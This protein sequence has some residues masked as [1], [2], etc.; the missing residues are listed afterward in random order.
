M[1]KHRSQRRKSHSK[2]K[3]ARRGQH[4][5]NLAGNPPS[6]WG[7]VNGTVGNGWTQFMNALTLQPGQNAGTIQSNNIVPTGN[8]NA[9][10]AQP[11]LNPN[12]GGGAR[13]KKRSGKKGGSWMAVA[14]Q[15]IVPGTLLAAQQLY[16]PNRSSKNHSRRY[17]GSRRR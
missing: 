9:Q 2:S 10:D 8:I 7:W 15:A 13:K 12:M 1:T 4:G 3:T 16:R 5:G 6:A 17:K 14:N 11:Y